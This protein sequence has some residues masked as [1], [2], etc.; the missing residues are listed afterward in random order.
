MESPPPD[1]L[2]WT[3]WIKD[4]TSV[5]DLLI[6]FVALITLPLLIWREVTGHRTAKSAVR[7]ANTAAERHEMQTHA[8]RER[9]ITDSFT[10]A[11]ELLGSDKLEARLG[12]IYAL[13][14]IANQSERHYWPIMETLT[15]Y[16]R[17]RF[18][19]QVKTQDTSQLGQSKL[20]NE[21]VS[22][23]AMA[24]A[25]GTIKTTQGAVQTSIKELAV[26]VQAVLTVLIRRNLEY[27]KP[28]HRINLSGAELSGVNLNGANL[29]RVNLSGA[30]LNGVYLIGADLSGADLREANLNSAT[31]T[32]ADLSGADLR[33]ADLSGADLREADL[34]G[35]DLTDANLNRVYLIGT[36]LRKAILFSAN[37]S[38][39]YLH[40]ADLS[41]ANLSGADLDG[42][43]LIKTNL[44]GVDLR[45]ANLRGAA[46]DEAD[47]EDTEFWNTIMPDG[48]VNNRD[49][50]PESVPP[51]QS[52]TSPAP[53]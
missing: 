26:G 25:E 16:V 34:S 2:S 36:N 39:A 23:H 7:Q 51:S 31:L 15:A 1:F 10:K 21:A 4:S 41:G 29:I 27:E 24:A 8:D 49:C 30:N 11:V 37:L 18:P 28:N 44:S 42:A 19:A 17:T 9:R 20:L 6:S 5:R 43:D 3:F 47:L 40:D 52:A 50:P 46:L 35:A 33:E 48:T 38:R 13:E 14:D 32:G 22:A 12:A 53:N 45:E